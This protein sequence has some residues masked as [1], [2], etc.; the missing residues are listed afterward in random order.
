MKTLRVSLFA[1][2]SLVGCAAAPRKIVQ[3]TPPNTPTEMC[4]QLVDHAIEVQEEDLPVEH[5]VAGNH[6]GGADF[7]RTTLERH[8]KQ[9][10]SD[11][12]TAELQRKYDCVMR[13]ENSAGVKSCTPELVVS[14]R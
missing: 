2:V 6:A 4:N 5:H 11:C 10:K 12:V 7:I 9:W 1:L 3:A 8:R 13:A 14:L